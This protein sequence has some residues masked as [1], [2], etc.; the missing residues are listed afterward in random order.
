[1]GR[2]GYDISGSYEGGG[3]SNPN[4]QLTQQKKPTSD[5]PTMPKESK[6]SKKTGKAPAKPSPPP[7]S[8]PGP[9]SSAGG[10]GRASQPQPPAKDKGDSRF[11]QYNSFGSQVNVGRFI[12][13][14]QPPPLL[15]PPG[16][17][18]KA[19]KGKEKKSHRFSPFARPPNPKEPTFSVAPPPP[20]PPPAL[21]PMSLLPST[22]KAGDLWESAKKLSISGGPSAPPQPPRGAA[23]APP[24]PKP[25]EAL[26]SVPRHLGGSIPA[27]QAVQQYLAQQPSHRAVQS[28]QQQRGREPPTSVP[29]N[30]WAFRSRPED[31][32]PLQ[33]SSSCVAVPV[34]AASDLGP[35]G[36]GTHHVV[37]VRDE[38]AGTAASQMPIHSFDWVCCFCHRNNNEMQH[39]LQCTNPACLHVRVRDNRPPPERGTRTT[40]TMT[41]R[42]QARTPGVEVCPDCTDV[43]YTFVVGRREAV[44]VPNLLGAPR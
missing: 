44:P 37:R 12:S 6:P 3:S 31:Q 29:R 35:Q 1:M 24:P 30:R 21:P 18:G 42:H 14:N 22:S 26:S 34:P 9:S 7:R 40:S 28:Q 5:D 11:I 39:P 32:Q 43:A 38:A 25:V 19:A 27:A 17:I 8:S 16:A 2:S 41:Y 10:S 4:K 36:P 33:P 13:K 20:P 23:R 15:P